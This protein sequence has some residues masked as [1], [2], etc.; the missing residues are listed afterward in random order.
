[1]L[2]K[3]VNGDLVVVR[4]APYYEVGDVVAYSYPGIGTVI[5]RIVEK[6]GNKFVLKGDNNT[7][8]DGYYPTADEIYG[9]LIFPVTAAAAATS[10]PAKIVR[11]PGP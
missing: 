6:Q 7:W 2:P 3:F 4:Q 5:H 11:E 8:I 9:K 1:M 10:G